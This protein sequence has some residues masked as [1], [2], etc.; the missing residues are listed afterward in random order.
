MRSREVDFIFK[1]SSRYVVC[2]IRTKKTATANPGSIEVN[3]RLEFR[4]L[5]SRVT[6]DIGY[7]KVDFIKLTIPERNAAA[8]PRFIKSDQF[9]FGIELDVIEV[10]I[11]SNFNS[12][13]TS[14]V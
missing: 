9:V 5:E 13:E 12:C 2:G 3:L 4:T 8:D 10:S 6:S 11:A 1:R 14:F 7:M